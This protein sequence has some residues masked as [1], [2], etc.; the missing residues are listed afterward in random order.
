MNTGEK[1]MGFRPT[2]G[3]RLHVTRII[4]GQEIAGFQGTVEELVDAVAPELAEKMRKAVLRQAVRRRAH[5]PT[6]AEVL[7]LDTVVLSWDEFEEELLA[8]YA[9]GHA[10]AMKGATE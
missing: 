9:S 10:A 3:V 5:D 8:A 1:T 2:R 4:S 7:T 6:G